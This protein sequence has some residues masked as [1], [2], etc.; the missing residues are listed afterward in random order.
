ME[1]IV[2]YKR[3]LDSYR[4]TS[5]YCLLSDGFLQVMCIAYFNFNL[6]GVEASQLFQNNFQY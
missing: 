3:W 1:L 6:N 2:K 4:D 5:F